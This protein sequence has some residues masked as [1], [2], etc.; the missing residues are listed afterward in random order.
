MNMKRLLA[1]VALAALGLAAA[2]AQAATVPVNIQYTLPTQACLYVNGVRTADPCTPLT[3]A[4]ALTGIKVYFSLSPIVD[5]STLAPVATLSPTATTYSST[6]TAS[7][8]DKVYVRLK[9]MTASADSVFSGQVFKDVVVKTIP[10]APVLISIG[11]N[12]SP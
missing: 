2:A 7:N 4:D 5:D 8:G 6:F 11:I 1:G 3:G 9:A 12:V 10:N